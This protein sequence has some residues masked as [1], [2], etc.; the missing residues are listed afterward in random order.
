MNTEKPV[1]APAPYI[2]IVPFADTT[3]SSWRFPD[4]SVV[5]NYSEALKKAQSLGME[6]KEKEKYRF[7]RWH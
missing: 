7:S 2:I 1:G 4:G 5:R 6:L 3:C